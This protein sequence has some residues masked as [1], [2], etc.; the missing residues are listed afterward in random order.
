MRIG[1]QIYNRLIQKLGD[2]F[3][4]E[5]IIWRPSCGAAA[6]RPA[7]WCR[8]LGTPQTQDDTA[9]IPAQNFPGGGRA[10]GARLTCADATF[11]PGPGGTPRGAAETPEQAEQTE[12]T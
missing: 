11:A 10:A 1:L 9:W 3:F 8:T 5:W 2:V 6:G 7:S 4:K 12:Q